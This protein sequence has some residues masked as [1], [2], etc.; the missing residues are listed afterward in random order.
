MQRKTTTRARLLIYYIWYCKL[1]KN[2]IISSSF[3]HYIQDDTWSD[4]IIASFK[5]EIRRV[6][7]LTK[8]QKGPDMYCERLTKEARKKIRCLLANRVK[9]K[10]IIRRSE[11]QTIWTTLGTRTMVLSVGTMEG[12]VAGITQ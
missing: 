1:Y 9:V 6:R 7:F 3:V 8:Q 12:N 11:S 4:N 2:T 10:E 5:F